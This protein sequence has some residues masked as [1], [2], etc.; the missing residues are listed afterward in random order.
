MAWFKW[1]DP[2]KE[3]HAGALAVEMP[4]ERRR[5]ERLSVI[6]L[7]M[8]Q[9]APWDDTFKMMTKNIN[10]AGCKFLTAEPLQPGDHLH[11][12][13]LLHQFHS[14]VATE[15]HILWVQPCEYQGRMV[16]EGG[17]EFMNLR[18]TDLER[19]RRFLHKYK[20]PDEHAF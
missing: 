3:T 11:L 10:Q 4:H 20:V 14:S 19:L 8:A 16:Y 6:M 7:I 13:M 2:H 17:L 9:R 5:L 1:W 12:Q 15:G 18:D